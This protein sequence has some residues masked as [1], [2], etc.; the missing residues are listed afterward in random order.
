[1]FCATF[2]SSRG[3][4]LAAE[5]IAATWCTPIAARSPARR[6]TPAANTSGHDDAQN[7]PASTSVAN[8]FSRMSRP[9]VS[10]SATEPPGE[11]S[12]T[13]LMYSPCLLTSDAKASEIPGVMV[14][15]A[16]NLP[17]LTTSNVIGLAI[18]PSGGGSGRRRL[19]PPGNNGT[20]IGGTM[21]GRS[22]ISAGVAAGSGRAPQP[23]MPARSTASAAIVT[24]TTTRK[25]QRRIA[26]PGLSASQTKKRCC[27][28]EDC[29]MA[30]RY[31]V[32]RADDSEVTFSSMPGA[33]AA[34]GSPST[35]AVAGMISFGIPRRE[36]FARGHV[37]CADRGKPFA[38]DRGMH[39]AKNKHQHRRHQ[40]DRDRAGPTRDEIAGIAQHR[41][42]GRH[43]L[44]PERFDPRR[45]QDLVGSVRQRRRLHGNR[46]LHLA[47]HGGLPVRQIGRATARGGRD[48]AR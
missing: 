28:L 15:V 20:R 41:L 25:I 1:M 14:P 40:V 29:G 16:I 4:P 39:D 38:P 21:L 6:S 45:R 30:I 32:S 26:S 2:I 18:G 42:G 7:F 22:L 34:A 44:K 5:L 8:F 11:L 43:G 36:Q 10:A 27:M 37:G 3:G 17:P 19:S 23:F 47:D 9:I 46:A 13:V 12:T 33:G 31:L 48:E 24:V 35:F